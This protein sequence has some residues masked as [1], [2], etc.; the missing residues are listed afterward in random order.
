M[1][2]VAVGRE[3]QEGEVVPCVVPGHAGRAW[4][5][6]RQDGRFVH[7]CDCDRIERSLTEVYIARVTGVRGQRTT[8][9][10]CSGAC[11]TRRR[12]GS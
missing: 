1:V 10:F 11:S 9:E 4:I 7:I 3:V 8:Q 5:V 12:R 2:A 6:R